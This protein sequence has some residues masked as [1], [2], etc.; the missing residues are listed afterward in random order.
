ME[1]KEN[2]ITVPEEVRLKAKQAVERMLT[3]S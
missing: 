3:I 2:I 1:F